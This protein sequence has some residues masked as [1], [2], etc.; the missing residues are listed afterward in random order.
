VL[1]EQYI[2]IGKVMPK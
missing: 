2:D 1:L